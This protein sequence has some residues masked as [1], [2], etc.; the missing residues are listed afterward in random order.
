MTRAPLWC[1]P[2]RDLSSSCCFLFV[3]YSESL[4][5]KQEMMVRVFIWGTQRL[6]WCCIFVW[7]RE[8]P[9]LSTI[10]LVP[11]F[12]PLCFDL[13]DC[14]Y[15]WWY[16][17][18]P[19]DVNAVHVCLHLESKCSPLKS[20]ELIMTTRCAAK[21]RWSK[22]TSNTTGDHL[23]MQDGYME[24]ISIKSTWNVKK[25]STFIYYICLPWMLI[26][27][28]SWYLETRKEIGILW[29]FPS[30]LA[31]IINT[32]IINT[33]I[34]SCQK[35]LKHLRPVTFSRRYSFKSEQC[36]DESVLFVSHLL[37]C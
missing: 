7:F 36:L 32:R 30:L 27:R 5:R 22:T 37:S 26:T 17:I 34:L 11:V 16:C 3:F 1:A 10:T 28:K 9:G 35:L 13:C 23:K 25:I 21:S 20:L 29:P 33:T 24:I 15:L 2:L 6:F 18:P 4:T 12:Y 31:C 19:G 14:D 8:C